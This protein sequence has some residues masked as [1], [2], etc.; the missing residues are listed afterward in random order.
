[1]HGTPKTV[2]AALD[3]NITFIKVDFQT[4]VFP[5]TN[6]LKKRWFKINFFFF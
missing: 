4:P 1:M 6:I 5:N 2:F 3:F